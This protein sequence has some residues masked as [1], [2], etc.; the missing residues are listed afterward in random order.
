MLKYNIISNVTQRI[1]LNSEYAIITFIKKN[2]NEDNSYEVTLFLENIS[3]EHFDI[4]QNYEHIIFNCDR[5]NICK[6]VSKY[7]ENQYLTHQFDYYIKRS[8][9]EME[10][11]DYG[12]TIKEQERINDKK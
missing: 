11:F 6:E 12:N 9:Y 2:D 4:M 10:C 1:I 3:S 7:I 8:E 5:K